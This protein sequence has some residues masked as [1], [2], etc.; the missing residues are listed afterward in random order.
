MVGIYPIRKM[1]LRLERW[2][3]LLRPTGRDWGARTQWVCRAAPY[4]PRGAG[5]CAGFR[6]TRLPLAT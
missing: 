5:C 2:A 3:F 4:R 1:V 6:L